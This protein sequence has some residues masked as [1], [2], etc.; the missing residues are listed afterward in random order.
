M[1]TRIARTLIVLTAA[2]LVASSMAERRSLASA[3]PRPDNAPTVDEILN[4]Y[5]QALGG[6]DALEK[7]TSRTSKGV[8]ELPSMQTKGS[9]ELYM[10]APNKRLMALKIPGV[11]NN[12]AAFNG[13]AGWGLS[14]EDGKVQDLK[15]D[16]LAMARRDAE[17][18]RDL[19]L[20]Q[21][22]PQMAVKGEEKV[23][24]RDSVRDAYVV[25]AV[26]AQGSPETFYFDKE[27]GLL[28]RTDYEETTDQGKVQVREFYLDYKNVDG[29]QVAFT[30]RQW[31]QG[32]IMIMR[33]SEVKQNTAID[34]KMFEKPAKQ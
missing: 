21:L 19:K 12:F 22:Y 18:Y 13:A 8:V 28:I 33:L 31:R 7:I 26:P 25:K 2:I 3:P 9:I 24:M 27:T 1:I 6:K 23:Q 5:V 10:K 32:F 34:D 14:S 16:E 11:I 15:G 20:K 30:V 29:V 4:K 17:F